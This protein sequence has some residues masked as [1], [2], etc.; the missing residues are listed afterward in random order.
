MPPKPKFTREEIVAAALN[1]VSRKGVEMLTAKELGTALGCSASPIFTVFNS[2]KEI[3]DVVC[4]E[5][6]RRFEQYASGDLSDMPLFKQIGLKMVLFGVR[7]PKLYQLLFMQE[8]PSIVTFEG[9]F[10]RLGNTTDI[11]IKAIENDY[12][13]SPAQAK[14]LFENMWIYTFG[15]GTLCA[16][17]MCCFTEEELSQ[18][19][20]TEFRALMMLMKAE[21][22]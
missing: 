22:L 18:M 20:S 7:E 14:Q 21:S 10:S 13:L 2:M 12:S 9:L 6:M 15:V 11:C 5:A 8:N 17:K 16:T 1:I 3:Q 19:L 4:K